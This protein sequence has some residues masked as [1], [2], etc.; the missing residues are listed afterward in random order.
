LQISWQSK[1]AF[2]QFPSGKRWFIVL[3]AI[4]RHV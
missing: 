4:S 2:G 1:S 3:N